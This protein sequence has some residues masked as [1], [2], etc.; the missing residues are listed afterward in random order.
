MDKIGIEAL[1]GAGAV[2]R[3]EAKPGGMSSRCCA[4]ARFLDGEEL[5]LVNMLQVERP[6]LGVYGVRFLCTGEP[7]A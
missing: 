6:I 5:A 2:S 3:Q 7:A 1:H 4:C